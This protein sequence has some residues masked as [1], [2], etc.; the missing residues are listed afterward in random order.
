MSF[1]GGAVVGGVLGLGGGMLLA[2]RQRPAGSNRGDVAI[3]IAA[4]ALI[5]SGV[6]IARSDRHDATSVLAGSPSPSTTSPAVSSTSTTTS[7]LSLG[8][9]VSVPNVVAQSRATAMATLDN[10]G[11]KATV[12]TLALANVPAG[13]VISQSPLPAAVVTVGTSVSLVVSSAT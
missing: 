2:R 7:S 9:T 3:A 12:E 8:A 4:L 13:F 11:L 1:F 5:A 6:A 10:L